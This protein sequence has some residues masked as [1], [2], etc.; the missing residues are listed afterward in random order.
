[1]IM[2][3]IGGVIISVF[4]FISAPG[5]APGRVM[6]EVQSVTVAAQDGDQLYQRH[7][8]SCH[9]GDGSGVPS[10]YP[11]LEGNER[12]NGDPEPLIKVMLMGENA[13]FSVDKDQYM[14]AMGSYKYLSDDKVANILTYIRNNFSNDAPAIS[15]EQVKEV[16]N[17][18]E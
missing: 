17:E 14:G 13:P 7:C 4:L 15:P 16:R 11:P 18:L 8:I 2:N 9:Q 1:M 12:V 6:S 10:M 3:I 5:S